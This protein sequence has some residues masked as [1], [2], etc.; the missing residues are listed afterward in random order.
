MDNK[1]YDF[2]LMTL[3]IL[4][5]MGVA[6]MIYAIEQNVARVELIKATKC[7]N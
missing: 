4:A 1:K 3:F 7:K 6:L 2:I 5:M